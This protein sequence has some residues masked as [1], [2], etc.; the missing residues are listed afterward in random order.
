MKTQL[1]EVVALD[2]VMVS[3]G[4]SADGG[5]HKQITLVESADVGAGTTGYAAL[6]AQ[7]VT[8]GKPEL[9]YTDEENNDVQ[10][11]S[12]GKIYG[13]NLLTGGTFTSAAVKLAV[14]NIVYPVGSLYYNANVTTNP[15]TLLGVG[16]WSAFGAGRIIVGINGADADFDTA[17]ETG[18]SKTHTLTAAETASK[19]VTITVKV[20]DNGINHGSITYSATKLPAVYES[21]SD[22]TVTIGTD[23]NGSAHT[24][25][26]PYIVV[27]VWKRVS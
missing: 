17:E 27:Y 14:L 7:T 2:H 22:G 9:V 26:N 16:T 19:A 11:T 21:G 12:D 4:S 1:R 6:G 10:I 15:A 3:N 5:K 23:A 13:D 24:I 20:G 18:G 25:M 8:S